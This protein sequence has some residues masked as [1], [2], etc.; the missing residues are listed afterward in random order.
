MDAWVLGGA[1][2]AAV[3]TLAL[4]ARQGGSAPPEL[5]LAAA[6]WMVAGA[7]AHVLAGTAGYPELLQPLL[8][9]LAVYPA[10]AT[11]AG[12]VWF[13]FREAAARQGAVPSGT[14]LAAGGIGAASA[15]GAVLLVGH[16][17]VTV[18]GTV[19]LGAVPV[20]AGVVAI[21]L[22]LAH[23]EVD[24]VGIGR[25][26]GLGML[27]VFGHA[28]AALS[29]G[30]LVRDGRPVGGPAGDAID[31]AGGVVDVGPP[32]I[33]LGTLALALVAL[34]LVGRLTR[35]DET[36]GTA[37]A[38]LVA[39]VGLGPGAEALLRAAELM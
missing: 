18:R 36:V 15:L 5:G 38:T 10:T 22:G 8:G 37:V 24:P 19:I 17:T 29:W 2:V 4:L 20:V 31:L 33:V 30:L 11:A 27:V 1:T 9:T 28:V 35:R 3:V 34:S 16:A 21:L 25:T 26:R 23:H 13:P 32:A 6:P 7:F 14:R 39:A 12:L